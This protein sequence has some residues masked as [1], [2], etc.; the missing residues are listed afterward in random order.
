MANVWRIFERLEAKHTRDR[1][2]GIDRLRSSARLKHEGHLVTGLARIDD[3]AARWKS[4]P[5]ISRA[6]KPD[7]WASIL[8]GVEVVVNCAGALQDGLGDNIKAVHLLVHQRSLMPA[9]RPL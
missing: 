7:D 5:S 2:H 6:T 1:F 8:A 3:A 4:R 9:K